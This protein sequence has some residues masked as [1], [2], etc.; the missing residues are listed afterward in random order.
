[1][2]FGMENLV[3]TRKEA[4]IKNDPA[5]AFCLKLEINFHNGEFIYSSPYKRLAFS[6]VE[7]EG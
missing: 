1:M 2:G 6:M 5:I 3:K 4:D 7:D